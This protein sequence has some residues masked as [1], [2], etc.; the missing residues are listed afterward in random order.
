[1]STQLGDS[2]T[3]A[4]AA[5]P[6][7]SLP[8]SLVCVGV[9]LLLGIMQ[10]LGVN[11]VSA[12]LPSLQGSLG[13]DQIEASWLVTAYLMTSVAMSP[14]VIKFRNQYGLRL[15]A[16]IALAMFLVVTAAHLLSNDLRTAIAMRAALGIAAAPL[17]SLAML[18]MMEAFP[19]GKLTMALPLGLTA[20]Q[21]SSPLARIVPLDL[22]QIGQWHGLYLVE[23]GLGLMAYAAVNLLRLPPRPMLP[24][25]DRLDIIVFPLFAIGT[26]LLCAVL[27][28]GAALWWTERAWLGWCA[29]GSVVC[30]FAAVLIE[31][32]RSRPMLDYR[33]LS[34]TYMLRFAA[35]ILLFRIVLSEQTTG[36]VGLLTRLGMYNE[37]E[38]LLFALVLAATVAGSL[39]MMWLM[40]PETL[41]HML[42][43]ALL[44]IIVASLADS[45]STN[46][47]RPVNF[48]MTQTAVAYASALFLPAA[49][50]AGITQAIQRGPVY[51][52][53]F[54]AIFSAGNN[55]GG[56]AG[57]A[58]IG[59]F[60]TW[61]EKF[62]SNQLVAGLSPGD[63]QVAQRL[64]QLSGAFNRVLG[65]RSLRAAEGAAQL[66]AQ[67]TREAYVLAYNDA[68]LL[69]AGIAALVFAWFA[70]LSLRSGLDSIRSA[71]L[72]GTAPPS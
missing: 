19:P 66:S 51:L 49:M 28:Q 71:P 15:F 68:F 60:V 37:Q 7:R 70:Y 50:F 2:R 65:D 67:A 64:Q 45:R 38:H 11:M 43:L 32:N 41:R 12:N 25:F 59:S 34:S 54:S 35:A 46:L 24:S 62:H 20:T 29:A 42:L 30:L 4:T 21:I 69:I 6:V 14:L 57:S 10:G 61:R 8:R 72:P 53:S 16:D 47:V 52:V 31:L 58:L 18:Y 17:S 3:A 55:L 39:T 9:S 40:K 33:W 56:L 63:P 1:L 27:S 22:L 48:Y 44:L 23:L 13:A 26:A 5:S 36:A